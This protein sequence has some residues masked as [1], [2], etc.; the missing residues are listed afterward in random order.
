MALLPLAKGRHR[1]EAMANYYSFRWRPL[2]TSGGEA[3]LAPLAA[4][5]AKRCGRITL[6]PMPDED[7]SASLLAD[8]FNKAGWVVECTP[9]DTNHI[10]DLAGRSFDAYFTTRPGALRATLARKGGHVACE[11]HECLTP[12]LWA[13]YQA[14]Y[15]ESWK[16][17]EGS[18]AFLREFAEAES[19][20]GRLRLGIARAT[21]VEVGRPLAAQ[22]WSVEAGT[23]FIHKLAYRQDARA[24]SPGTALTAAMLRH[25]IDEDGVEMV[26]YGTGNEAYKRDWMEATRPRWRLDM[27]R[28]GSIRHW[29]HIARAKLRGALAS[30]KQA[31]ND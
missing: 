9:C 5:L 30:P 10:L 2:L 17:A 21:G 16:P 28:P 12:D 23:A 20:A 19:A 3:L 11:V 18:P 26:D 24:L 29:P 31:G 6:A 14:I 15:A 1:L 8:A 7:G 13:A 25:V 27:F 4:D 22:L